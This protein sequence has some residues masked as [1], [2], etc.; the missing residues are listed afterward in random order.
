[1]LSVAENH[2]A[3]IGTGYPEVVPYLYQNLC[4]QVCSLAAPW[5]LGRPSPGDYAALPAAPGFLLAG[6][7]GLSHTVVTS[8]IFYYVSGL[9]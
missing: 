9:T 5:L 8:A 6:Y 2:L 7:A 1:M 3:P 4:C